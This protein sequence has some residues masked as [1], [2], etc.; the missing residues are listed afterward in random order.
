M[1]DERSSSSSGNAKIIYKRLRSVR[2]QGIVRAQAQSKKLKVQK[3]N[4]RNKDDGYR[5]TL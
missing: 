4:K 1:E 5:I 2:E 3:E